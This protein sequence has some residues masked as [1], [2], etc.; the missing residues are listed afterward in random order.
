MRGRLY[1]AFEIFHSLFG[2]SRIM[3][4]QTGMLINAKIDFLVENKF[5]EALNGSQESPTMRA[6]DN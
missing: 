4:E 2:F 6:T 3:I 5:E 1:L